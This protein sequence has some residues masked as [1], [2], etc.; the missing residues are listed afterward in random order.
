MADE[1]QLDPENQLTPEELAQLEEERL[2]A[3]RSYFNVTRSWSAGLLFALPLLAVYE[4]GV[5]MF[6]SEINAAADVVKMPSS[7]FQ[8]N[9]TQIL[10]V[11]LTLLINMVLIAVALAAVWRV[12]RRGALRAG[13]FLGMFSESLLYAMILG[14]LALAPITGELRFGGFSPHLGDFPRNLVIAAGAGFYEEMF[15]R[16]IILGAVFYLAKEVGKLR[17]FSAGVLALVLSGA[18]FSAAHFLGGN[19]TPELG[20]FIYRLSAGMILGLVFLT[21]GFGIAAWTHAIYDVYILC[22]AAGY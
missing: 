13:T 20:A 19:E 14:P 16:F 6:G 8:R 17:P 1:E 2:A 3:E 12:G 5:L 9:P 15:F 7:W 4:L 18:F 11:D 21:R 10:G 22:F